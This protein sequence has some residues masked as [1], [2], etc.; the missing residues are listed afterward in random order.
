M[1]GASASPDALSDVLRTVRLTGALFF[2]VDAS[3]PWTIELPDGKA[4]AP[5]ILPGAQHV[6]SYHIVTEGSCW[7][8]VREGAAVRLQAGDV[9]VL[10]H[11]DAYAMSTGP[12][13]HGGPDRAEV[14]AFMR[15]MATGELPF[16]VSEG[17]GGRKRLRLVCGFLGCDLEPFNPLLATLPRL[18]HVRRGPR[19]TGDPLDQLIDFTVAE[20]RERRAGG[21]C[22][23]L[24]LSELMFVEVVRRHLA[25]LPAEETGWLAGLRDP[26][27]GRALAL[28]HSRPAQPWT[29]ESL[30]RDVGLSRSVLAERFAH[31]V[32]HPPMG[33][34]TRWRMQ[35]AARLLADG[36]AKVSAVA[37]EI[38]YDS[39]AAFSRAFKRAA[40]M[41]PGVWRRRH[42]ARP[43][44]ARQP[45]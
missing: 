7:G 37:R 26:M 18:L 14:L 45:R 39:E 12:D 23:R 17:G 25:T 42:A 29:L 32:G 15:Q 20:S 30:A 8:G 24:R 2:L 28:L 27:V 16:V 10:P 6:I 1:A 35:V 21:E 40:G 38:G 3:T 4:L 31:L 19:S 22:V 11:G 13:A 9:L 43:A 44:A 33:Y 41:P 36:L 34:L 5:A